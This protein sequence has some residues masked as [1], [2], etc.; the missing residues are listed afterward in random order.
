MSESLEPF[1]NALLALPRVANVESAARFSSEGLATVYTVTSE[2]MP[3]AGKIVK[4]R[5]VLPVD[6]PDEWSVD[7]VRTVAQEIADNFSP[8]FELIEVTLYGDKYPRFIE[9]P[10][11]PRPEITVTMET[12]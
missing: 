8:P 3:I 12:T 5:V 1:R 6:T 11:R 9:R 2:P 10:L 7:T 4:V